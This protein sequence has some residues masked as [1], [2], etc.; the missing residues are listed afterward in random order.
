[1]PWF[2]EHLSRLA[3]EATC[4]NNVTLMSIRVCR[5]EVRE[6]EALYKIAGHSWA[7]MAVARGKS[8]IQ[9]SH[10]LGKMALRRSQIGAK[11]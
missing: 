1:M 11:R 4:G 7:F 6:L 3:F 5:P 9:L 2:N 10:H 8:S